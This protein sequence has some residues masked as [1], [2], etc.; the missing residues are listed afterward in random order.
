MTAVRT[1]LVM[2]RSRAGK[3]LRAGACALV[4]FGVACGAATQSEP[5]WPALAKRWYDRAEAGYRRVDLEDAEVSVQNAL[6]V[7]PERPEI[8]R[9]AARIALAQL[10]Y[11]RAVQHLGTLTDSEA[12]ALRARA[13]W[14]SGRIQEAADE[15]D[16][17]LADPDVHDAWATE[18]AKLARRGAGRTPFRMTGGLLA[19]SEMPQVQSTAMIVPL[20]L[21][22]EPAL[23]MVATGVPEAVVDSSGGDQPSWVSL[24]FGERLEVKDVPALAQDLSGISRQVNAPIKFLIGVNLLR[25]L[26]PTVDFTGRQFVVRSFEPPPPPHATTVPL[27]YVRGG[28][29]M[30]KAALGI[31]EAAPSASLLVETSMQFAVALDDEGWKKVGFGVNELKPVPN[32]Q[33][34]KPGVLPMLRLGAFELPQVPGVHG[35]PVDRIQK[36]LDVDLD[37]IAGSTL[38][39]AFRVTLIDGG[40]AMWLEDM[41][42]EAVGAVPSERA[43]PSE[44]EAPLGSEV[45]D[46][47]APPAAG[48]TPTAPASPAPKSAAPAG[49][50]PPPAPESNAPAR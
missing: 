39:A 24:R 19:V 4:L 13:L 32:A 44:G 5:E 37:G 26:N 1:N 36:G 40:R 16:R 2:A 11:D 47:A 15:L 9:L 27:S 28:G 6:R 29:M 42:P 34:V 3:G 33:G 23:G 45:P 48:T 7:D 14:Y 17:L 10:E 49:N 38:L 30:L 43:A 12:R 8:R 25:H 41:P 20:E 35:A 46:A 31:E 22:G 18:V 50:P 21:N